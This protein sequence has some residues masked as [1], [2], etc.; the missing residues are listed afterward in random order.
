MGLPGRRAGQTSNFMKENEPAKYRLSMAW[1]IRISILFV[2]ET[3]TDKSLRINIYRRLDNL[4]TL[5]WSLQQKI[6]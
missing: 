4:L 6:V 3:D 5:W 2:A 1:K